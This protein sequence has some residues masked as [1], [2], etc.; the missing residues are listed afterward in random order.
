M[1][2]LNVPALVLAVDWEGR[3]DLAVQTPDGVKET[4]YR[5]STIDINF[6]SDHPR[7]ALM[8][9]A[10]AYLFLKAPP[11]VKCPMNSRLVSRHELKAPGR[12]PPAPEAAV[13]NGRYQ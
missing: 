11:R 5:R 7:Q 10:P 13:I 3:T 1:V 12:R 9:L 2:D 4:K 8:S 6:C